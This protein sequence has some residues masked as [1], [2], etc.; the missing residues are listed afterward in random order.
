MIKAITVTNYLGDSIRLELARPDL[1]GFAVTSIS[2]LG[3]GTA[4]I[5]TTELAAND[6]ALYNSARVP[7]RNIVISLKYLW[8]ATIEDV[9]QLSYRYF[10]LKKKCK[11]LIE[12]DNRIVD[13]EGYVESND[14]TIFSNHE[15]ADVS[16]ICPYPYFYSAGDEAENQT[17]FYSVDPLFEFPFSNESLTEA[18]LEM[19]AISIYYQ[20]VITYSGDADVGMTITIHA[21]GSATNVTIYNLDTRESMT[22][23]T[24]KLEDL[25]GSG[26]TTADTITICTVK[27]SKS[28]TLLRDGVSTNI[29]NCLDKDADWFQ[30]S[31]GDNIFAYSA[32]DGAENLHFTIV[33]KI[34][35]EGV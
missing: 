11:L 22:I 12:T 30:L 21:V 1:S 23:D 19:G 25:T 15:G 17:D 35:Y 2:G 13:I 5:N 3:P 6:G 28:I 8:N 20:R 31:N 32:E 7:S 14:P 16:I 34:L 26:I 18:L 33:N 27:G 24:D 9:R 29:L 10:P 4:T